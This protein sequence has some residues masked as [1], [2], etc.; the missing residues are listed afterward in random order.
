MTDGQ[1]LHVA[2]HQHYCDRPEILTFGP[3]REDGSPPW[4]ESLA[5]D[6]VWECSCGRVWLVVDVPAHTAGNMHFAGGS[7]WRPESRR[8]RRR[9]LGLRWWR[10]ERP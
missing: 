8:A 7:E 2:E 9:R 10:R 6:T 5:P 4:V 1:F 3:V